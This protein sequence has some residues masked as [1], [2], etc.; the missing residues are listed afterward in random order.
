MKEIYKEFCLLD[1]LETAYKLILAG[2][3]DLQEINMG[4]NFYHL[5]YQSLASGIERLMK[6]Y[7]CLVI[8]E[9]KGEFPD[10]E[11]LRKKLGHDLSSLKKEI[12]DNHF[13]VN[14][15]PLLRE[16]HSFI[17]NDKHLNEIIHI[18]SEF[19]KLGRYY[20]LDVITGSKKTPIDPK[21]KWSA[22]ERKIE[23]YMPYIS[24]NDQEALDRDYYAKV[25]SKIIAKLE[26]FIRAI[27]MQFIHGK[28]GD[29]LR[30]YTGDFT[31]FVT[32]TDKKIGTIDYRRS[33]EILREK[34]EFW[35]KRTDEEALRSVWPTRKI[36]K[37]QYSGE[38]PFRSDE[39]VIE[40]RHSMFC[41]V[42][43]QGYDFALNG[44]A[45]GKYKYPCPHATGV[46]ILGKSIGSFISMALELGKINPVPPRT[47]Y[48]GIVIDGVRKVALQL[49]KGI[50]KIHN[51]F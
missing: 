9:E 49:E 42:N 28:H 26:R 22:L 21:E 29:K 17:K 20:N 40:C 3:G 5:P 8:K 34:K 18:L 38:W 4:N 14:N 11:H 31:S 46:A 16:D 39:V 48:V 35:V 10:T 2:F 12:S 41:I 43:I 1:E 23:D 19:G 45:K 33:V 47:P 7:L 50:L 36:F 24:S 25:N 6:C 13:A 51:S 32:L 37:S 27:S 44:S 15:I 30:Q